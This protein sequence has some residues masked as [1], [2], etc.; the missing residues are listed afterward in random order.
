MVLRGKEEER[1][2]PKGE[3]G[4]KDS[5]ERK[6]PEEEGRGQSLGERRKGTVVREVGGGEGR[7]CTLE[8]MGRGRKGMILRGKEGKG[9]SREGS[10]GGRV[11]TPEERERR[12]M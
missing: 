12:Y 4:E 2:S 6:G 11:C 5:P 8:E 1:D 7:V 3:G 9:D 10:G